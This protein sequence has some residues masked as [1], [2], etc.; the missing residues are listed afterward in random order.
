M[1]TIEIS[2]EFEFDGGE[3]S[4]R[5]NTDFFKYAEQVVKIGDLPRCATSRRFSYEVSQNPLGRDAVQ[6]VR[7]ELGQNNSVMG[8]ETVLDLPQWPNYVPHPK[9]ITIDSPESHAMLVGRWKVSNEGISFAPSRL[10]T[11]VAVQHDIQELTRQLAS[12]PHFREIIEGCSNPTT[13]IFITD[14]IRDPTIDL[15]DVIY[16]K[17]LLT[18]PRTQLNVHHVKT[19]DPENPFGR[20]PDDKTNL[21]LEGIEPECC[22][23]LV[24][25]DPFASGMQDCKALEAH[26]KAISKMNHRVHN[27]DHL[28]LFSPLATLEGASI[29]SYLAASYGIQTTIFSSSAILHARIPEMYWCPP[30]KGQDQLVIDPALLKVI[31]KTEGEY[32]YWLD[33]WCNWAA[34][35][36]SPPQALKDSEDFE[37]KGLGISNEEFLKN[38]QKLTPGDIKGLGLDPKAFIAYSTIEEALILGQ[39]DKL[40]SFFI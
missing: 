37:L 8:M 19:D 32:A 26:L 3:L 35:R 23:T 15:Q 38:A 25:C 22:C 4:I 17:Y 10:D 40:L 12:S 24:I 39:V 11:G 28:V 18:I 31:E 36:L 20:Y 14:L 1:S 9:I 5:Y 13:D 30:F 16:R 29:I 2:K 7:D 6:T 21:K 33:R 34:K 27:I